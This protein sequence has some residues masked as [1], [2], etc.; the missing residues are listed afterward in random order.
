LKWRKE[1]NPKKAATEKH[2]SVY[3]PV[4]YATGKD[5]KGRTITYNLYG[6][7]DNEAVFPSSSS[8]H[9]QG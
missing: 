1:F 2:D 7:L 8:L 5:K 4:G 9:K 6:G 3:D